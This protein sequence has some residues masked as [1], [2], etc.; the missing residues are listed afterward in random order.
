MCISGA[1]SV[2]TMITMVTSVMVTMTK[3]YLSQSLGS[4]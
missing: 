3:S 2:V 4:M 1:F